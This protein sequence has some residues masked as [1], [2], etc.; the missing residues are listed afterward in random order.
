MNWKPYFSSAWT[1]MTFFQFIL[2]S[3]EQPEALRCK[4]CVVCC[5]VCFVAFNMYDIH[6]DNNLMSPESWLL[7]TMEGFKYMWFRWTVYIEAFLEYVGKIYCRTNVDSQGHSFS[8]AAFIG[9]RTK[10]TQQKR[11]EEAVCLGQ[12][13]TQHSDIKSD[14]KVHVKDLY[15]FTSVRKSKSLYEKGLKFTFHLKLRMT[16]NASLRICLCSYN[17]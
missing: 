15:I 4:V 11:T 7:E 8:I 10:A 9:C 13:N 16:M 14:G 6:Q 1:K 3:R 5:S 17:K 2:K 12:F